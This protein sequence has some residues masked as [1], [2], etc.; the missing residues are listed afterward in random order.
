V[1]PTTPATTTDSRQAEITHHG[2]ALAIVAA[3]KGCHLGQ[4]ATDLLV[5]RMELEAVCLAPL[6]RVSGA[7]RWDAAQLV[8]QTARLLGQSPEKAP[9]RDGEVGQG[10]VE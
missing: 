5:R 7:R 9:E 2:A 8:R 3:L 4:D 1:R 10:F 6:G